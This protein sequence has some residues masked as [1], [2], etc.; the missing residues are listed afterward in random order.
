MKP[1]VLSLRPSKTVAN[2]VVLSLASV[3]L[4]FSAT[5][6]DGFRSTQVDLNDGTV[7][8]A[9]PSSGSA[10][11]LNVKLGQLDTM[12]PMDTAAPLLQDGRTVLVQQQQ[13]TVLVKA[14]GGRSATVPVPMN[15]VD[16]GGG[17]GAGHGVTAVLDGAKG[18]LWVGPS[19]GL[20]GASYP[21]DADATVPKSSRLLV[22]YLGDVVVVDPETMTWAAAGLEGAT[23][24]KP[25]TVAM[26]TSSQPDQTQGPEVTLPPPPIVSVRGSALRAQRAAF[27]D[28]Q[29]SSV[30]SQPVFLFG[31]QVDTGDTLSEGVPGESWELQQPSP[32]AT[33]VLVASTAGLY[34]VDRKSG[35]VN[36]LGVPEGEGLPARPVR[37]G[38]CA[39][40][41]WAIGDAPHQLK[42][43]GS[44]KPRSVIGTG[45]AGKHLVYRVNQT[46]VALNSQ[47]VRG[48]WLQ[49][50]SGELVRL[51]DDEWGRRATEAPADPN[52]P[53]S[54]GSKNRP[55]DCEPNTG[56][57]PI[58]NDDEIGV[59]VS[60]G[61]S[62]LNVLANDS[63]P[64]CL[65]LVITDVKLN[66]QSKGSAVPVLTGQRILFSPSAELRKAVVGSKAPIEVV[67]TYSVSNG[68][69]VPSENR[70]TVKVSVTDHNQAT[71][72]ANKPP[73][74]R[75]VKG[76]PVS[77][78]M[79]VAQNAKTRYNVLADWVDADGDDLVLRSA[80]LQGAG[81]ENQGTVSFGPD[82][83]VEYD[84]T[85]VNPGS[86]KITVGVSDG[87]VDVP[88]S[89]DITVEVSASA[90]P[91]AQDD[92]ITVATGVP[93]SVR[94]KA[95]DL[96]PTGGDLRSTDPRFDTPDPSVVLDYNRESDELSVTGNKAGI[97]SIGYRL[98]DS[99]DPSARAN[100][101]VRVEDPDADAKL[102]A[103][104]DAVTLQAGRSVDV[105]VM[106]NDVDPEHGLLGIVHAE[107][108]PP[109]GPLGVQ[110]IDRRILRVSLSTLD[111]KGLAPSGVLEVNY[112]VTNGATSDTGLLRVLVDEWSGPRPLVIPRRSLT[113]RSGTVASIDVLAPISIGGSGDLRLKP[114]SSDVIDTFAKAGRG[115]A[116]VSGSRVFVRGGNPG[117]SPPLTFQVVSGEQS[118]AGFLDVK[119]TAEDEPNQPPLTMNVS[120]RAARLNGTPMATDVVLPV[121]L[122]DPNGDPITV[123]VDPTSKEGGRVDVR[124]DGRTVR[125]TPPRGVRNDEFT[126][127]FDDGRPNGKASGSVKVLVFDTEQALDPVA[128]D[129]VVRALPGSTIFVPVL[130]NDS[131]GDGSALE[132]DDPPFRDRNGTPTKTL[133][134]LNV[135]VSRGDSSP[136]GEIKLVDVPDQKTQVV[137]PYTIWNGKTKKGAQLVVIPDP[138]APNQAPVAAGRVL[139]AS[140]TSRKNESGVDVVLKDYDPDSTTALTRQL[141]KGVD[142][143]VDQRTREITGG[144]RV[145]PGD[146]TQYV[147]YSVTDSDARGPISSYGVI[148]VPPATVNMEPKVKVQTITLGE[149]E[150]EKFVALKDILSDDSDVTKIELDANRALVHATRQ[151]DEKKGFIVKRGEDPTERTFRVSFTVNDDPGGLK[152]N[153]VTLHIEVD[154]VQKNSPPVPT[155]GSVEL[156]Q[157]DPSNPVSATPWVT[158]PDQ[159]DVLQYSIGNKPPNV[160]A[161]ITPDGKSLVVTARALQPL[162]LLQGLTLIVTDSKNPPVNVPVDLDVVESKRTPIVPRDYGVITAA[163]GQPEVKPVA[164]DATNPFPEF[165]LVVV[166][167]SPPT[168]SPTTANEVS[169]TPTSVGLTTVTYT[170]RDHA[171]RTVNGSI[172]FNV[173]GPPEQPGVAK[174]SPA[175]VG[176]K[177]VG[178]TWDQ[179]GLNGGTLLRYEVCY[180]D[181]SG[182]CAGPART[183]TSPAIVFDGLP[184][185]G[186][187]Y[188]F[189]VRAITTEWKGESPWS[190]PSS[191]ATPDAFP[192]K[193]TGLT[194]TNYGDGTVT[195]RWDPVALSDEY[196]P[197]TSYKVVV[198]GVGEF[199]P[200]GGPL[201]STV[202]IK[203]GLQNG[204]PGGRRVAYKVQVKAINA[205]GSSPLSD[206]ATDPNQFGWPSKAPAKP[207]GLT[208]TNATDGRAT[209]VKVSWIA[210]D[211]GGRPLTSYEV[212]V[213]Q[214]S[215]CTTVPPTSNDWVLTGLNT[216]ANYNVTVEAISS[217][218]NASRSGKTDPVRFT[219]QT[220]PTSPPSVSVAKAGS[221]TVQATATAS[222][223][224]QT[225]GCPTV[226]FLYSLTPSGPF[227]NTNGRF[228]SLPNGTEVKVY[229]IT[230]IGCAGVKVSDSPPG[231]GNGTPYGTLQSPSITLTSQSG[232]TFFI[233][234]DANQG[235]NGLPVVTSVGG[236]GS[237]AGQC[238]SSTSA[239]SCQVT[240]SP[241]EQ[242]G[243]TIEVVNPLDNGRL[244]RSVEFSVPQPPPPDVV[245]RAL[246]KVLSVYTNPYSGGGD[247]GFPIPKDTDVAVKCW[248]SGL[249]ISTRLGD[250]P[251][252]YQLNT[253]PWTG[254]Y[255]HADAFTPTDA[256]KAPGVPPC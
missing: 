137:V 38:G 212:C 52:T 53:P 45:P 71:V 114:L 74:L 12:I 110:V 108:E 256:L 5:V 191:P 167:V 10:G 242:G 109:D 151:G 88:T 121:D 99:D 197:V 80:G 3:A 147:V 112:T 163:L 113:V 179:R 32:D 23:L 194:F 67:L 70:A 216:G 223:T 139:T 233:Q 46:N 160:D 126:Y 44:E 39:Y 162:G 63:D 217:D 175:D 43:C 40:G 234:W 87:I 18:L 6:S 190:A 127:V 161:T 35:K 24:A 173:I 111:R 150:T 7:W 200:D 198:D 16:T 177:S 85:N 248:V 21:Q 49:N 230:R 104:P 28:M 250:N 243:V 124:D 64:G 184:K 202:Q 232:N 165:P 246:V 143:I 171:N 13:K 252:W 92:F 254:Y 57:A 209:A 245:V 68:K 37:V 95:N 156:P 103:V 239:G 253:S 231:S 56:G 41:A 140:E 106:A 135:S 77:M 98:G 170:L 26:T 138:Q 78:K 159:G 22:T 218:K 238:V 193:P 241:G 76:T 142:G 249:V 25:E 178:L 176:S 205:K 172:T 199:D 149:T 73:G 84:A 157:G 227:T 158:D 186:V 215:S 192:V 226:S 59:R 119:V 214:T 128:V 134:P 102:T 235:S 213:S 228:S 8:V 81:D 72:S 93:G 91:I 48:V 225:G 189:K 117:T 204:G 155:R 169:F 154:V 180:I 222:S 66:D 27:A 164:A 15:L 69:Q 97:Y 181:S 141:K 9:D 182:G 29:I 208:A 168:A 166:G 42:V 101:L 207:T 58:A 148:V 195:A 240:L 255:A 188:Q 118:P 130:A 201:G 116:W 203:N 83:V 244:S 185:N 75:V 153:V 229:A 79:R 30:G 211:D 136:G 120:A 31:G 51:S 247:Q 152:P 251:Y 94:I 174:W 206:P 224:E 236:F 132:L 36:R 11:R 17:T 14:S 196:S 237:A 60:S 4:V 61:A 100:V 82:G 33:S 20:P 187:P 90:V 107:P 96:D 50:D 19:N 2:S 54:S 47:D 183:T 221:G 123:T 1:S 146:R 34:S 62:L 125:Y 122:A 144:I 131:A 86:Y 133:P 89:A 210:A 220:T 65:P 219:P 129:D 55:P 105:D 145:F 115:D